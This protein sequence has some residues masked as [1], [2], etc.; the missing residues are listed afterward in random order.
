M[1]NYEHS[2]WLT[3]KQVAE[4]AGMHPKTVQNALQDGELIGYQRTEPHGRW[5]IHVE[6]ADAW[7]RGDAPRERNLR[8]A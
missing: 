4:Y 2:P 1:S 8:V 6:D 3:T 5:R 7:I